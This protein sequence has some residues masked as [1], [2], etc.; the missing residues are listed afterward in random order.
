MMYV[1]KADGKIHELSFHS[2]TSL[3]KYCKLNF[4]DYDILPNKKQQVMNACNELKE[5]PLSE[6]KVYGM[7]REYIHQ[8]LK[9][10]G[11]DTS[12]VHVNS[13]GNKEFIIKTGRI[14]SQHKYIDIFIEHI[15]DD[16]TGTHYTELDNMAVR[17]RLTKVFGKGNFTMSK[18]SMGYNV[19]LK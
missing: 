9:N 4:K 13:V 12:V 5:S 3:E 17:R 10:E 6:I 19:K 8:V 15:I 1:V 7:S 16:P 18:F 14:K 11:I 2:R